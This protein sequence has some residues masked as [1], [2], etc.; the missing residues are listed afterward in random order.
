[1]D[2]EQENQNGE[3]FNLDW[4]IRYIFRETVFQPNEL[5]G[6]QGRRI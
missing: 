4:N 2:H 3:A 5:D 1:M 6:I